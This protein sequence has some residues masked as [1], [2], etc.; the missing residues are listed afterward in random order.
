MKIKS[1]ISKTNI[2]FNNVL[3]KVST[4]TSKITNYVTNQQVTFNSDNKSS[5]VETIELSDSIDIRDTFNAENYGGNQ[6]NLKN[7]VDYYLLNPD[8]WKIVYKYYPDATE[9]DLEL[10]FNRM[11]FI[12]CGYVACVN[13]IVNYYANKENGEEEFEKKFGFPLKKDT[14]FGLENN[15][16]Y[17]LL[18]LDF[19]LYWSHDALRYKT[20]EDVYGNV[21][22]EMKIRDNDAA[23]DDEN[24]D[25]TGMGGTT[26]GDR[27]YVFSNYMAEH[28][29]SITAAGGNIIN[30]G[31]HTTGD[32]ITPVVI[33]P[34]DKAYDVFI[35]NHSLTMVNVLKNGNIELGV[36]DITNDVMKALIEDGKYI[37]VSA[38]DFDLEPLNIIGGIANDIPKEDIGPHAMRVV[39]VWGDKLVVSSWGNLYT[40]D[41]SKNKLIGIDLYDF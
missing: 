9:E 4:T 35:N 6:S 1:D 10:L 5:N 21:E 36:E 15:Y 14:L 32:T 31:N 33:K 2:N 23:L 3:K 41:T 30:N 38:K 28:G 37:V 27:L 8:V 22:E 29:I 12:G 18:F 13:I 19:F 16:N 39:D 34:G 24:F 25:R 20:I 26:P 7:N 11:S 17:D 40:L